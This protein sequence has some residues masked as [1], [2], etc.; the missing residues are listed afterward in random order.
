MYVFIII[1]TI[2]KCFL[3]CNKCLAF[4]IQTKYF[5]IFKE[6]H[7]YDNLEV[8]SL[9]PQDVNNSFVDDRKNLGVYF[10]ST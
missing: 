2:H 5:R 10:D 7:Y 6:P 8:K 3:H 4:I 9:M 1:I